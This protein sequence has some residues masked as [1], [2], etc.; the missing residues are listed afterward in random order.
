MKNQVGEIDKA[1]EEYFH[2]IRA[3]WIIPSRPSIM[4]SNKKFDLDISKDCAPIIKVRLK[5]IKQYRGV[6]YDKDE[7]FVVM[8]ALIDTGAPNSL[9]DISILHRGIEIRKTETKYEI[10]FFK[11]PTEEIPVYKVGIDLS[12]NNY[13]N[14]PDTCI[15]TFVGLLNFYSRFDIKGTSIEMLIGRDILSRCVFTYNG[16]D[17]T[18]T[19][20]H[21]S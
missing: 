2:E 15:D 12:N 21:K 16:L 18:C 6:D 11:Q 14:S 8:N 4:M 9:I 3:I 1:K 7:K 17:K 19:L 5:S 10:G 20:N 13:D